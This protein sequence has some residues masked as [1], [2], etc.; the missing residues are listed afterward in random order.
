MIEII[1]GTTIGLA[2]A[3]WFA[4]DVATNS[5]GGGQLRGHDLEKTLAQLAGATAA[6]T[7]A[8]VPILVFSPRVEQ[9]VLPFVIALLIG[10]ADYVAER[11]NG[12]TRVRSAVFGA[13]TLLV[14]L[15]VAAI[16]LTL[17]VH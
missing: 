13:I 15:T 14:A 4:F 5:L 2:L 7:I 3:H 16:K 8:T 17:P 12:R 6:A 10:Y 1:W 11:V 9:Q